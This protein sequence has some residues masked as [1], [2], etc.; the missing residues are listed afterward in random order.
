[1]IVVSSDGVGGRE[2][3]E[4]RGMARGSPLKLADWPAGKLRPTIPW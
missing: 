3:A 1:M 4:A 2:I